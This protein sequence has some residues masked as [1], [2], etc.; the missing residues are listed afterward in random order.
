M[1]TLSPTLIHATLLYILSCVILDR[2]VVVVSGGIDIV[3]VVFAT[4]IAIII[5]I[6]V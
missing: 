6:I 5:F 4:T 3:V 1:N 2:F